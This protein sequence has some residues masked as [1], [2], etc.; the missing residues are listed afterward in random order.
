MHKQRRLLFLT[1][2]VLLAGL[3]IASTLSGSVSAAQITARS[4]T[5][6][7]VGTTGGA[8]AGGTVN[9]LFSFI[10]PSDTTVGSIKFTYCTTPTGVPPNTSDCTMPTGLVTTG[11][12]LGTSS[13]LSFNSVVATTNGVPYATRTASAPPGTNTAL[14]VQLLGVQNPSANNT[15]FF[16]RIATYASTDASGT[17]TDTGVVAAS[18]SEPI[19]L[20]GI[21]P[22]SLVFC[23]GATVGV[24]LGSGLPD[25]STA[26]TG[27][28]LF[29]Q[30]FSPTDTASATSQMAASTNAGSGYAITANG[31]TLT[32]GSNT[33]TGMGATSGLSVRGIAQFGL[34]LKANV[35]DATT[36]AVGT[37]V[38]PAANGTNYRGQANTNFNTAQNFAF[39]AN[40]P[41]IVAD[42]AYGGPGGTD[43]QI[44]TAS[45]IVNVPGSQPAGTY[46]TTLTYICTP[47][48]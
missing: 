32:S 26:T 35:A 41:N 27:A 1:G 19:V 37:E 13:G 45:Y 2:A 43:A 24:N 47:T 25:C 33:I 36:P 20:S 15:T 16:V 34:N 28:V 22:E 8:K 11:A 5:L 40:T 21:M 3:T 44:F 23:T 48:F 7:G 38:A 30:L 39:V 14:T 10:I 6:Q 4:L 42:S 29:N 18:T 31:P 17:P 12:T 9:H 46:A